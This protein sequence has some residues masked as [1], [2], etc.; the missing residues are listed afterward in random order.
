MKKKSK[1]FLFPIKKILVWLYMKLYAFM[2][3]L[4]LAMYYVE[5]DTLNIKGETI[6]SMIKEK[7]GSI[8]NKFLSGERDEVYVQEFYE[9][10]RKADEFMLKKTPFEQAVAADKFSMNIGRKDPITGEITDHH[11]FFDKKH[12][13]KNKTLKEVIEKETITRA[14][15]DDYEVINVHSNKPIEVGL[16]DLLYGVDENDKDMTT[17]VKK[18]NKFKFPLYVK[19]DNHVIN[20]IEILTETLFIKKIGMDV[21]QLEFFIPLKFKTNEFDNDNE[22]IKE[23]INIDNVFY[24]E[25]YGEVIG[26]KIDKFKKRIIHNDYEVFKFI[27]KIMENKT[28]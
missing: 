9:I 3:Y 21:I 5:K 23:L 4:S 14:T 18:G 13:Y 27:G 6:V 19:R 26:Y 7:K 11:G 25:K 17:I 22:I 2:L 24:K 10:L 15:K 20:K 1:Y 12:K 16:S 28:I 8:L